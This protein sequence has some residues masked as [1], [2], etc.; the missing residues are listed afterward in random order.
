MAN[1]WTTSDNETIKTTGEFTSGGGAIEVIPDNTTCLAMID[2]AGLAEFQGDE[3]ISLRWVIAE[4][5][6][7]KGRKIFQK[8]RVFDP[9]T[10]RSDKAKKML[11]AIDANCGGKLAQSN[12]SPNDT[13]MAKALLNKPMLIKLMTWEMNDRTGNWVM[14]VAPRKGASAPVKE[15][16]SA[17]P[18]IVEIDS[19][20]W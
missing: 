12:E 13:A 1:F 9:D 18:S 8:V 14:S 7:Y 20:P 16:T 3:Y 4:P 5:A 6:I 10:K 17:E 15:E 2:E 11:A 19:I